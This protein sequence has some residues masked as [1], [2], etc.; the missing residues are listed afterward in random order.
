MHA[1]GL[2]VARLGHRVRP[3]DTGG[4]AKMRFSGGRNVGEEEICPAAV[5]STAAAAI[6]I[7]I[8]ERRRRDGDLLLSQYRDHFPAGADRRSG[9]GRK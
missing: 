1:N 4:Y 7:I 9:S 5:T 8:H 2:S 3:V 6:I